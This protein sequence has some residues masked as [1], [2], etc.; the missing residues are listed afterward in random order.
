MRLSCV[1]NIAP[2]RWC[3]KPDCNFGAGRM[4]SVEFA[5][6]EQKR[7]QFYAVLFLNMEY[8]WSMT[9]LN[10]F[11]F[12]FGSEEIQAQERSYGT[13]QDSQISRISWGSIHV[14]T[15]DFLSYNS[16]PESTFRHWGGRI[17]PSNDFLNPGCS[18]SCHSRLVDFKGFVLPQYIHLIVWT[19]NWL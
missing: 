4:S 19:R 6:A 10:M 3:W 12:T 17:W 13:L 14:K 8:Y 7:E 2:W 11:V 1:T 16:L 9:L 18:L 5:S 15:C